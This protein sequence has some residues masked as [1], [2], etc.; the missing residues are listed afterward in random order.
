MDLYKA[1]SSDGN[2]SFPAV[3]GLLKVASFRLEIHPLAELPQTQIQDAGNQQV[4][5]RE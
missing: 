3:V 2:P 4:P 5:P 1:L